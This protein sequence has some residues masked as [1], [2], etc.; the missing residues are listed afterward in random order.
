MDE[1]KIID[2]HQHLW[3]LS[4][5][6]LPWLAPGAPLTRNFV[7]SD[8]LK[9]AEG[10]NVVKTVY[11]EVDAAPSHHLAEAEYVQALIDDPINPTAAAVIGGRPAEVGFR[12]YVARFKNDDRIK[13]VRQIL[14]VD[15][16]PRGMC[17]A[18]E[19]IR[20]VRTLGEFGKTFDLCFRPTELGDAVKLVEACP[21]TQ[22]I[23]DHC[24][25]GDPFA[26]MKHRPAG[27]VPQHDVEQYR[28]EIDSLARHDRVICKISGI[29][30]RMAGYR[31]EAADLAPVV[32]CCLDAFGPDRVI[33]GGDWPVCT[34]A[35]TLEQ[36]TRA[37]QA[38]VGRRPIDQQ[39]KLFHDNAVSLYSL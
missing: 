34:Q 15:S 22:F 26:F 21:N 17:L 33:F 11:M 30:V 37:L 32:D 20:G 1:L 10:L 24:G 8:Y 39:R 5:L 7:T 4:V 14:H 25:Y 19:F 9:A 35:A 36:W 16:A 28:R 3:D 29:V 6:K 12:E 2:T 23:L 38:I 31:W 27:I 13:G 18:P